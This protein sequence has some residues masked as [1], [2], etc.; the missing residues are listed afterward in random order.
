M[1]PVEVYQW[2]LYGHP[3]VYL[4]LG[5]SYIVQEMMIGFMPLAKSFAPTNGTGCSHECMDA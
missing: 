4:V 2:T 5:H 1:K 3:W